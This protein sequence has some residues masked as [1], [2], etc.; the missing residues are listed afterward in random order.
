VTIRDK[1]AAAGERLTEILATGFYAGLLPRKL[2]GF[3]KFT[4][5]GFLGT[6]VAVLLTPLL[7]EGA[8]GY[9]LFL[10]FFCFFAVKVSNAASRQYGTHDDPRIV[11]DEIA[12]YWIATAFMERTIF[13]LTTAFI[14]FRILDTLKPWPIKRLEKSLPAGL[15]IVFDD[16]LAGAEANILTRLIMTMWPMWR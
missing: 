4:G 14:L 1:A 11:I 7:P 16:A 3:R 6:V 12:G 9:A 5:A 13:S 2:T 15:G 8:A 10:S